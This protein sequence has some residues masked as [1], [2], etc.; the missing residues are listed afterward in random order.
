LLRRLR[1]H[2][3]VAVVGASGSGKSSLVRAG[4]LPALHGGFLV[5][6]GARWRTVLL[7]PG[8]APIRAL[9]RALDAALGPAAA[10]AQ[11]A[12]LRARFTEATLRRSA[13][14]LAEVVAQTSGPDDA[15]V[16][17]VVDQFEEL[18][19]FA[20]Q[21]GAGRDE[22]VA[23]VKLLLEAARSERAPIYV[24]LTMR[25]DF[26]GDCA[27][28]RDLPEAINA[29]QFLVPRMT[30]A[31]RQH[32][33]EGPVAVG[34]ARIAPRLVQRLLNDVG[35]DPDQ[36]P[37]L[38][39]ALMRTW[40]AWEADH[41]DGEPL[42]VRHYETVG[43]MRRALSQHG[44]EV[45]DAL[46]GDRHR[47]LA[48]RVFRR[49]TDRESDT[50]G[51][52]RP[53]PFAELC[54]V[55]Q[56]EPDE[57]A[58]VLDA[59]RRPDR[60][61]LMPP[62]GTPLEPDTVVDIAH[63]SLMRVWDRLRRWADREAESA[64]AYRRLAEAAAL[65]AAGRLSLWED[66]ELQLALD[67]RAAEQPTAAWAAR[68]HPGFDAAM[69]FLDASRAAREQKRREREAQRQRELEQARA[70][71]EAQ[72]QR[73][74][75]QEDAALKQRRLAR[76]A[77]ALFALALVAALFALLFMARARQQARLATSRGL[78]QQ[79][80]NHLEDQLDLA[81]LL[82]VEALEAASTDEAGDALLAALEQSPYLD[83]FLSGHRG[84]VERVAFSPAVDTLLASAS[85]DSTVILW[86]ART[87]RVL[88]T[89]HGSTDA[90]KSLAF[91]PSG[92]TLATGTYDGTILLWEVA[93]RR[94]LATWQAHADAVWSL[95]FA[96]GGRLASASDDGTLLLWSTRTG[97][98]DTLA[99]PGPGIADVAFS[100]SGALLA[101][102]G[103]DSAVTLWEARTGRRR[104]TLRGHTAQIYGVAFSPSGDT[105]ASA[106]DDA[107][108]RLWDARAGMPL[109]T[110]TGHSNAVYDA[111]FS[112]DGRYLASGSWDN[113]V[114]LW[115]LHT[116]RLAVPPLTGHQEYVP[117]VAFSASGWLASGGFDNRVLLWRPGGYRP[118]GHVLGAEAGGGHTSVVLGTAFSPS[119]DTLASA[120]GDN[121]IRLWDAA[122]GAALGT[123]TGH[124]SIVNAVAFSPD[125]RRL[126]S[127]SLDGTAA[128]WDAA[129][130]ARL[131]TVQSEH[132]GILAVAFSPSG[133]TLATGGWDNTITLWD[134]HTG[135][136][137][138]TLT[139]HADAVWSLAFS[140]G[141]GILASGSRD[142]TVRLWRLGTGAPPAVWEAHQAAVYSVA[143]GPGADTLLASGS[144]DNTVLLWD[145]RTGIPLDTLT[146]H[147]H[148]VQS[149][150]FSRDARY[151]ASGSWDG[152]VRIWEMTDAP[153]RARGRYVWP[154][155]WQL[156]GHQ[157][158][159]NS[160][161]FSPV[162]D[163][164]ASASWDRTIRLWTV[165]PR[166][167]NVEAVV[168]G[169]VI[170]GGSAAQQ[171][172]CRIANRDLTP[173]EWAR[174]LGDGR[175]YR[176][177]CAPWL[178]GE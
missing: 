140:P 112:P 67:W 166:P 30:R 111:A 124:R 133:D 46:P 18:F 49:L 152:I 90:V 118:T 3:F 174:F 59:F 51:I 83:R 43:T 39:H 115:D 163:L 41:A 19:R 79:V 54:A 129:T 33:I 104:A 60:A 85:L 48:E 81:M 57:V 143:F 76:G 62:A 137:L 121:T 38:Q 32:A 52:R 165:V 130:G 169:A 172:A 82:G 114:R 61:L 71:A 135:A 1:A 28:F 123:L 23:F 73:A 175:P 167:A 106:G 178:P 5:A 40:A 139:G 170:L 31:Q 103:A 20:G 162:A 29:S 150:A 24:V 147:K 10:D 91:S 99:G 127:G 136:L 113:T 9:A 160:V 117:S 142:R 95:A 126:A 128:V 105:L 131:Q 86:S 155:P 119:G 168:G 11:E 55:C 35:D 146:G 50:R 148:F 171:E 66:P 26:L 149:V 93:T 45:Y 145:T 134:G 70:L 151:V 27:R 159:V 94:V 36:L 102:A 153:L 92:D 74:E 125:G 96:P 101:T 97:A 78:A 107:T 42:D 109:G 47:T 8:G 80:R 72:R 177:T 75:E 122:T 68:Y 2:R 25:S 158:V 84:I 53:T 173:D 164:L 65:H 156:L 161:A 21:G 100:P 44:D 98:A 69:A 6:A 14:G 176:Q 13:L 37:I 17:V 34:G 108:V 15:N 87:G 89:L 7:R 141:G 12:A 56:A 138:H 120:S 157:G 58:A 64:Q 88:G 63:E 144:G 4:L 16:L 154:R 22:A 132:S 110:L 77:F 116:G